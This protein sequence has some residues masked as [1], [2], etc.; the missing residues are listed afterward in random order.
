MVGRCRVEQGR[1]RLGLIQYGRMGGMGWCRVVV[2]GWC[3]G[4]G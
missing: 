4:E 2:L 3:G 1:V